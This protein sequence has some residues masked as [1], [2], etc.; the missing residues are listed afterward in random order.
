MLQDLRPTDRWL[1]SVPFFC[2]EL[3]CRLQRKNV[4]AVLRGCGRRAQLR[5]QGQLRQLLDPH[6]PHVKE[7]LQRSSFQRQGFCGGYSVAGDAEAG[8]KH[9]IEARGS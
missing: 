3:L 2:L 7:D 5:S 9:G 8:R 6:G 1:P 4:I